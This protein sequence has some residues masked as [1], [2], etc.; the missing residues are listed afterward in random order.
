[1]YLHKYGIFSELF[2]TLETLFGNI[3]DNNNT[4]SMKNHIVNIIN[5]K[6]TIIENNDNL[7]HN[8]FI[9][10]KLESEKDIMCIHFLPNFYRLIRFDDNGRHMADN[11]YNNS[12]VPIDMLFENIQDLYK[13]IGEIYNISLFVV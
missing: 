4:L 3:F 12:Y 7:Y 5:N 13:K 9:L 2:V 6:F 10:F 1:M 8:I 11:N